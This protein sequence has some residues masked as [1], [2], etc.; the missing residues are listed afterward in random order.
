[1]GR[2]CFSYLRIDPFVVVASQSLGPIGAFNHYSPARTHAQ[3]RQKT[4]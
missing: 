3:K 4:Q 2:V 1:M